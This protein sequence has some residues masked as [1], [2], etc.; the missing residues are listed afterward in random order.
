MGDQFRFTGGNKGGTFFINGKPSTSMAL[1]GN[2]FLADPA[3]A[4][5]VGTQLEIQAQICAALNR[6]SL[7]SRQAGTLKKRLALRYRPRGPSD[8]GLNVM[9][10]LHIS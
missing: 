4:S 3:G 7:S 5:D 2:G 1:L 10:L 9:M 8:H 6:Q